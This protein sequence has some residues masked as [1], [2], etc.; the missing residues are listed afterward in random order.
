MLGIMKN[1]IEKVMGHFGNK[2][3]AWDVVNE[4]FMTDNDNGSG[5]AR[6]K[7]LYFIAR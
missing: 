5:N 7:I 4:A 3:Y 6:M 1:H 2:V